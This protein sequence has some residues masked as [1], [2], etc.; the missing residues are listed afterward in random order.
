MTQRVVKTGEDSWYGYAMGTTERN[1]RTLLQHSG[2][3]V[4]YS[5]MLIVEPDAGVGAV[6]LVNGP[7]DPGAVAR[8]AV[9]VARAALG[10]EPLPPVPPADDR[11]Q[12]PDASD[13]AGE[14]RAPDGTLTVNAYAGRLLVAIDGGSPVAA[15]RR[16]EDAF[17]V[18][19]PAMD[20]F[21]LR[22]R[23]EEKKVTWATH[24]GRLFST[25]SHEPPAPPP[26]EW[27]AYTGHYRTT[28]AWFNNFRIVVRP[29]GLFLVAPDGSETKM[30]PLGPGLF[31]EEGLSS[32]RLRFDSPVDGR[33]LR[34]NL[35]GVDYYRVFT[36]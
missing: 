10:R 13:Y 2:G 1:G 17:L 6:V 11:T 8:F 29:D 27:Q 5:S 32:E 30:E 22:F 16:G 24:G 23:R 20:R 33:T 15:E 21:L 28:H 3:M 35:S 25:A 7:G 26:A 12:V 14:Y 18:N 34:A 19:T 9:D 31:K 36:R 4:G